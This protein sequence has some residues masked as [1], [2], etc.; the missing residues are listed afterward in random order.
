MRSIPAM[1][2]SPLGA[3]TLEHVSIRSAV[4]TDKVNRYIAALADK[5]NLSVISMMVAVIMMRMVKTEIIIPIG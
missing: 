4:L 5:R 2:L 1:Y 3:G